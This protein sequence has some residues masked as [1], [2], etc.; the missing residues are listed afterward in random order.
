MVFYTGALVAIAVSVEGLDAIGVFLC[1][2][3]KLS[4]TVVGVA[5]MVDVEEAA[6]PQRS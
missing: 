1:A 6:A 5:R 4:L 2:I 3:A